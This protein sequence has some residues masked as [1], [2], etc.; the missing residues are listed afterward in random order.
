MSQ[1]REVF[2]NLSE[3]QGFSGFVFQYWDFHKHFSS[4][5]NCP[6]M[7]SLSAKLPFYFLEA[8]SPIDYYFWPFLG[9]HT[10]DS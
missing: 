1:E 8:L 7:F 10:G 9:V 5:I 3:S 6:L 4:G 2:Y